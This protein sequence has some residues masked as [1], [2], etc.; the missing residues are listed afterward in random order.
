MLSVS[1]MVKVIRV[2]QRHQAH[3][4]RQASIPPLHIGVPAFFQKLILAKLD[5]SI[6][7]NRHV[8]VVA[9]VELGLE[10]S[11]LNSSPQV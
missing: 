4:Q 3:H 9:N 2:D 8:Y 7:P 11:H 10:L 1:K 5:Y 6:L